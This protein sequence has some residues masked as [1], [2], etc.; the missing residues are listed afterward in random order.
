VAG[1]RVVAAVTRESAGDLGLK[2]GD[3][4]VALIEATSVMVG[5]RDES[6]L[7]G[8]LRGALDV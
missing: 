5:R 3:D 8:S 7:P 4:A 6:G 2:P 1:G